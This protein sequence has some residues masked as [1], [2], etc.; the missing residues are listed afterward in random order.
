MTNNKWLIVISGPTAVGKTALSIR[1][2]R[3]FQT[4]IISADSRQFFKEMVI[5]T[6]RPLS[7]EQAGIKHHFLG[8][9]SIHNDYNA[10]R[11]EAEVLQL[12]EKKF[13]QYEHIIMTGGSGLYI[14]AVCNGIDDFPDTDE[15]L[16]KK[17]LQSYQNHGIEWLRQELKKSDPEYYKIVDLQN[18]KRLLRALEVCLT[19]GKKYS[20]LRTTPAKQRPFNTLKIAINLPRQELFDRINRRTDQMIEQGLVEEARK[21]Y[22]Y[23]HVNALNTVGYKELFRYFDGLISL[24]QAIEDI[25]TQTRRYAKRQLTWLKKDNS[26]HW[27]SPQDTDD[28]ISLI[29]GQSGKT[30]QDLTEPSDK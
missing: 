6:A 1:L 14:D 5:G 8:H 13:N 22:H 20:K 25:K 19:S 7:A 30:H 16:R 24:E 9:L 27:F 21:L 29:E 12:L 3:H 10:S 15:S 11:F 4:E 2:A 17:L 18:P 26:L 23:R 28:I